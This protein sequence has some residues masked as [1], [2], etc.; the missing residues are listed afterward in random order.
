MR[1]L[2]EFAGVLSD[3]DT[4]CGHDFQLRFNPEHFIYRAHFP[5]EPVTPG[6]CI[7]QL[8]LELMERC[9]GGR[10]EIVSVK[11]VKFLRTIIPGETPSLCFSVS[12]T[13]NGGDFAGA[14]ITAADGTDVYARLSLICRKLCNNS[15]TA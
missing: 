10:L 6:V 13:E 1:L 2:G 3:R 14:R 4:D 9:T 15:A 7:L 12:V 8:A 11:N 5:G